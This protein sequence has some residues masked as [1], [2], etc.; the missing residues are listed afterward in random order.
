[1]RRTHYRGLPARPAG[2]GLTRLRWL[3][4]R[5]APAIGGAENYSRRLLR[6]IGDQLDID[7]VTLLT[8][9]RVDWLRAL[10]DGDRD[11]LETYEIDGRRV[12]ALA[13][14]PSSTRRK[15]RALSPFYHLPSSAAPSAMGR[16][17][18]PHMAPIAAGTD[19]LHNVFMGREAFSLGA[20]L[21][22]HRAGLPFVFTPL[23]HERPL[24]WNSP[25]FRTLYRQS[26]AVIALTQGEAAWLERQGAPQQR[27]RVI[28]I[29]PQNDPGASPDLAFDV[30]RGKPRIVL[31][32]GQLHEYKGFRALLAAA[33]L[34]ESR[35]DVLF[36]FAGPD[37]RGNARHFDRVGTNVRWLRM[38]DDPLRDSLLSACYAVCVP[39]S[40]E[41]FGSVVIEAWASGKPV[42]GGPAAATRELIENGVD[43]WAV[44]QDPATIAARLEQLLDDENLAREMGCRG[45]DKVARRFSWDTVAQAHLEVY[46]RVFASK[47]SG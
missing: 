15:L 33:R 3:G 11:T 39:S 43:G 47:R 34:L 24:G 12:T 17:L 28:G 32:L 41:S 7:V 13:R 42:V 27:L 19:V 37:V 20:M 45:K 25:A 29:G 38:V 44:A 5:Y 31:F 6:Q 9:N 4:F 36:V 23:R 18:A 10:V 22:V 8:S 2:R 26:D 30:L 14:W 40:R 16:L 46:E 21:A 35:R 1:M